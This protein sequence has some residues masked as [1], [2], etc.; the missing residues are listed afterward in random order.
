MWLKTQ[1]KTLVN[2]DRVAV[3]RMYANQSGKWV[4]YA[5]V[6]ETSNEDRNIEATLLKASGWSG[7]N[8]MDWLYEQLATGARVADV[9][10]YLAAFQQDEAQQ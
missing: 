9:A 6:Q 3:V 5:K 2:M 8:F 7:A 4:V 10:E 1:D